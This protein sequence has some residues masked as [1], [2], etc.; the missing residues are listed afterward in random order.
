MF[1]IGFSEVLL[2]FVIALVVLGPEKLPRAASQVGRWIGRARAMARQFKEQLEEEVNLENVRKAHKEAAAKEEASKDKDAAGAASGEGTGETATPAE[3]GAQPQIGSP[4]AGT[5]TPGT[6]AGPDPA[7]FRA[8]TF[9]HAH[10]TNEYGANPLTP[11]GAPEDLKPLAATEV[12]PVSGAAPV[13][14]S[15]SA[16]A[17]QTAVAPDGNALSP[18]NTTPATHAETLAG[19]PHRANGSDAYAPSTPAAAPP[20]GGTRT[21]ASPAAGPAAAGERTDAPPANEPS[22]EP[23]AATATQSDNHGHS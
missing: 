22:R 12:S 4:A 2:I 8:D 15:P 5:V 9:S 17:H 13:H 14:E 19:S 16:A 11:N 10:P 20:A 6:Y 7:D 21:D 3:P 18:S 1:D 23:L